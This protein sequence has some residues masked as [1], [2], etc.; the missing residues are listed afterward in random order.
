MTKGF[1][2]RSFMYV[3]LFVLVMSRDVTIHEQTH[4]HINALHNVESEIEYG[5]LRLSGVIHTTNKSNV[6]YP[7]ELLLAQDITEAIGYQLTYPL[8]LLCLI[9]I[10]LV[11]ILIVLSGLKGGGEE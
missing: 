11:E 4:V 5:F 1:I 10:L 8:M 9:A 3:A 7:E 6:L 2:V